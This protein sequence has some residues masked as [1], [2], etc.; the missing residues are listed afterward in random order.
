MSLIGFMLILV[1]L[2]FM[3]LCASILIIF[4]DLIAAKPSQK[5]FFLKLSLVILFASSI[6][7]SSFSYFSIPKIVFEIASSEISDPV[8][9][10]STWQIKV[11]QFDLFMVIGIVYIFGAAFL[12]LRIF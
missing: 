5:I 8:E 11:A 2:G 6:A 3:S 7:V 1:L 10:I 12:L 4:L 9:Q